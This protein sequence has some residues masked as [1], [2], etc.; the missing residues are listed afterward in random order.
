MAKKVLILNGSPIVGGNTECLSEELAKGA[1]EA[2]HT[3]EAIRLSDL[4]IAPYTGP[5]QKVSDDDMKQ[6]LDAIVRADIIV[7]A[8]PVYWMFFSAQ[9]KTMMD[10][11]SFD[12][13]DTIAGKEVA[14]LLCAASPE[15]MFRPSIVSYYQMCFIGSLEWKDRGIVAAGGAYMP[16]DVKN[17]P[18]MQQAYELGKSL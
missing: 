7:L 14:M 16:G 15:E 8:S 12:M 4:H 2:G 17:T 5:Q 10:R 1:K 11:L 9:I 6:V 18:Y 3:V 13:K